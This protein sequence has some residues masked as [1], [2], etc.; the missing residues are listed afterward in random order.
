MN[1]QG[2]LR[3]NTV[4][5]IIIAVGLSVIG[6]L[7]VIATHIALAV[8]V[9][10]LGSVQ[11]NGV[12]SGPPPSQAAVITAPVANQRFT[13]KT[14]TVTGTC[15]TNNY[16]QIFKNGI[17]AGT[18]F[19]AFGD[20][21]LPIDLVPGQN[22]LVARTIDTLNQYGPDSATVTVFY[23]QPSQPVANPATQGSG[24]TTPAIAAGTTNLLLDVTKLYQAGLPNQQVT[25]DVG[26]SGGVAPYALYINWGDGVNDLVLQPQPGQLPLNHTYRQADNYRVTIDAT[27]RAGNKASIQ[28]IVIINGAYTKTAPLILGDPDKALPILSIAWQ[29]YTIVVLGVLSYWLGER[30]ILHRYK[31]KFDS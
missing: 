25:I 13:E 12:V 20:F 5:Y 6:T 15:S 10:Q 17:F 29:G 18:E 1:D 4:A 16:I 3:Q 23:D 31:R 30:S 28:T 2:A 7:L 9:S 11:V 27:D 26:I 8:A 22:D 24:A 21:S 19:C 14:I